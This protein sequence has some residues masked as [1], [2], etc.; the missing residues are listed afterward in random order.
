MP[1]QTATISSSTHPPAGSSASRSNI[2]DP[3]AEK[4]P[5]RPRMPSGSSP[6]PK[7]TTGVTELTGAVPV[8]RIL[9]RSVTRPPRVVVS[10]GQSTVTSTLAGAASRAS[11]SEAPSGRSTSSG[12]GS[13]APSAI[14]AGISA[15]SAWPSA[16]F[17]EV[18]V[19]PS[20]AD[21]GSAGGVATIARELP[22]WALVPA[23]SGRV[24]I[25][26]VARARGAAGPLVELAAER[27]GAASGSGRSPNGRGMF[28]RAA[29]SAS[30][31]GRRTI[32][33]A[34]WLA[35]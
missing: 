4:W 24:P 15:F 33:A 28:A 31:I 8:L 11:A 27:R 35:G 2:T 34:G 26:L 1:V 5:L 14:V 13:V 16:S 12:A 21:C 32:G 7:W 6:A 17:P 20:S 3:S 18:S 30:R 9:R 29:P 22:D 25:D 10:S 19:V 23:S